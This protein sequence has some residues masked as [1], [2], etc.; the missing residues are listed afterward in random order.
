MA[1]AKHQIIIKP[2]HSLTVQAGTAGTSRLPVLP[3]TLKYPSPTSPRANAKA[4]PARHPAS[5]AAKC[6][7]YGLSNRAHR[8]AMPSQRAQHLA[9]LNP[10]IT[11]S[12]DPFDGLVH[13][14][15]GVEASHRHRAVPLRTCDS[16]TMSRSTG[17]ARIKPAG[18]R[19]TSTMSW[20]SAGQQVLET[21]AAPARNRIN[22]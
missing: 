11:R 21:L 9:H 12:V 18:H 15:H 22:F 2:A 10:E 3:S 16:S 13:V 8:A 20:A 19:A 1:E 6:V 4:P 7:A 5:E 14:L 17:V